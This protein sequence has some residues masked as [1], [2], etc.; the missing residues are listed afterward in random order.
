MDDDMVEI[1]GGEFLMG[2]AWS[3]LRLIELLV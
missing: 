3:L 1:P 2:R